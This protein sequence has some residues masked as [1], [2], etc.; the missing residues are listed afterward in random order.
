M[1]QT[2]EDIRLK[3][4]SNIASHFKSCD[5]ASPSGSLGIKSRI[6]R[7]GAQNSYIDLGF[8]PFTPQIKK[9]HE[10]PIPRDVLVSKGAIYIY[11]SNNSNPLDF[12]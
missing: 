12:S 2:I 8:N 5:I 4:C 9:S 1:L 7:K 11:I 10:N 3:L 6:Q